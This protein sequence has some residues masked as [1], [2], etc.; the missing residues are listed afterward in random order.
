MIDSLIAFLTDLK[1]MS[2]ITRVLTLLTIPSLL[3]IPIWLMTRKVRASVVEYDILEAQ[4]KT[5]RGE[6]A[7]IEKESADLKAKSPAT[8][9]AD[10]T[11]EMTNGNDE[12]AMALAEG[13]LDQQSDALSLAF[14]SRMDEAIR[15]SV[16][17]GAPAFANA[18]H[19]ARAARALEPDDRDLRMLID[20]LDAAE[21]AA[22]SGAQVELT[23]DTARAE[24]A[25]RE[26]RLPTDLAA[27][28]SAFYKA[29]DDGHYR[30]MLFLA[31]HGL[32]LTKRR[33]FGAESREHLL[34]RRHRVEALKLTGQPKKALTG[35]LSFRA[36][37]ETVF[38]PRDP[39]M[40]LARSLLASCR[41]EIGDAKGA[42]DELQDLLPVATEVQGKRHPNVLSS[43]YTIAQCRR[44]TGD[45][46]GALDELQDL[47]PV[48]TEVQGKRHPLVL[49]IRHNIARCRKDTGDAKSALDELQDLLPVE[50]EVLG[51]RHPDVLITRFIIAHCRKDT[52]DAKGALDE[53]QDLLPVETEV[54]GKQHPYVLDTRRFYASCLLDTGQR[55]EAEA[56][57]DGVR[58]GFEAAGLLPQHRYVR[59][60]EE[61]E[62]RL[63]G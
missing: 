50:T 53:L 23:D 19:W 1:G 39:E 27:L 9:I 43:R 51:E 46:K 59:E 33:P 26:D 7:K 58:A 16:T 29:G 62:A 55:A 20:E 32:S 41:L 35:A 4:L 31:G 12:R 8:F 2:L 22:A 24:Q 47:L 52:G 44:E 37:F 38:G 34:F 10:H 14:R 42:L 18:R 63:A 60:L 21:A 5:A 57:I 36:D 28:E 17:D 11:R 3:A 45:A 56:M 61:V 13:F 15:Q 54:L 49:S 40:F 30:L 48:A 6:A 25:K